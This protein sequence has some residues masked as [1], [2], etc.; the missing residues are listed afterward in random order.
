MAIYNFS[1]ATWFVLTGVDSAMRYRAE[2]LKE[3]ECD[4]KMVFPSAPD[5]RDLKLFTDMGFT[6]N[7]F[8]A[9]PV[10]FSDV[11][12]LEPRVNLG[13]QLESLKDVLHYTE[14]QQKE[15]SIL[16]KKDGNILAEIS[17]TKEKT[18]FYGIQYFNHGCLTRKDYYADVLYSSN[19][20]ETVIKD[21]AYLAV[22]TKKLF[23]NR[24][25]SVA[26]IQTFYKD[27]TYNILPDG[28]CLNHGQ[29]LNLFVK[30]LGL[31]RND[32]VIIDRPGNE[33][34]PKTLFEYSDQTKIVAI[35]HSEHFFEKGL[36]VE[37][38]NLNREY[39]CWF[40][41]SNHIQ[42]MVVSTEEQKECLAGALQHY[43]FAV[44]DIRVIP[45]VGLK[46]LSYPLGK[47]KPKSMVSVSRLHGRKKIDWTIYTAI[48]AHEIDNEITLDIYGT[49]SSDY[50]DYLKRLIEENGASD[51][52]TLKGHVDVTEVYRN[53]E[54]FLTTSLWETFGITL[55]EA[56]GSGLALVGLDVRYG[57]RLFIQDGCNGYL[58]PY[59]PEHFN[60]K[61]PLETDMLAERIVD[62]LSDEKKLEEFSRRS[63]E[64][65]EQYTRNQIKE[66][67]YELVGEI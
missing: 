30:K 37:G 34:S 12:N 58:V 47:R 36:T 4:M 20:Y 63:Y 35:F 9:V 18:H 27:Q 52:I 60:E 15:D 17:L 14:I 44:P 56:V 23:Y 2:I 62:I 7:Q 64:I 50:I 53:Y 61:C 19:I 67:W 57:N 65:A 3:K 16:L 25:G 5:I 48:K 49:G 54:L 40:K 13:E 11:D 32:I 26:L 41:Y 51:Y 6:C 55:L 66:K 33:F 1:M 21:G 59:N 24:D 22:K 39:W 45:V 10:S 29:L 8:L 42:T 38:E 46:K 31:S 28:R 43:G